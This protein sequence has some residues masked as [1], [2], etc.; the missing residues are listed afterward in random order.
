[1][2]MHCEHLDARAGRPSEDGFTLLEL[3]MVVAIIAILITI[4]TPYFFSANDRAKDKATQETLRNATT[5]A[6]SLYLANANY[7][8]ATPPAMTAEVG[9]L[10]FIDSTTDPADGNTVSVLPV[11]GNALILSSYSK[12][13]HCFYVLDDETSGSTS[14]AKQSAAGGCAATTAPVPGDPAWT[15]A[16]N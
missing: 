2:D 16:W 6:K 10:A 11:S 8:L 7:T 13:G 15:V 5:G 1:M 3:M 9:N 4:A 12:A 14:Y